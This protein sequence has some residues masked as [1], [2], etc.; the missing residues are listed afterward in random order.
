MNL[1]SEL[2]RSYSRPPCTVSPVSIPGSHVQPHYRNYFR[3]MVEV[4]IFFAS[5]QEGITTGATDTRLLISPVS[6][7][8]VT[9][10]LVSHFL[11]SRF[12]HKRRPHK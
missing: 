10:L 8:P 9:L 3:M 12:L 7:Y 6:R 1:E 5:S 2:F 4:F 11:G